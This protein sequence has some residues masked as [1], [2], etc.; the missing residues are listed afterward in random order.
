MSAAREPRAYC[1]I[2]LAAWLVSGGA[3]EAGMKGWRGHAADAFAKRG[4]TASKL[5]FPTWPVHTASFGGN[6]SRI[7]WKHGQTSRPEYSRLAPRGGYLHK[8]RQNRGK[9]EVR[10]GAWPLGFRCCWRSARRE[11]IAPDAAQ[12]FSFRHS[13]GETPVSCRKNF[14]RALAALNP[15]KLAMAEMSNDEFLSRSF[16]LS[17]RTAC[18]SSRMECPAT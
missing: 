5:K 7:F 14:Q 17:S 2:S 16:A 15:Q 8:T 12:A 1:R 11:G 10:P 18:I 13:V 3:E 6:A 4:A 9:N